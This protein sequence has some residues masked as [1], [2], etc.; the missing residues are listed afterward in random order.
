MWLLTDK[1]GKHSSQE[2]DSAGDTG[3]AP[4][5][6]APV[7]HR[8]SS[9]KTSEPGS[10]VTAPFRKTKRRRADLHVYKDTKAYTLQQQHEMIHEI[11][12]SEVWFEYKNKGTL[13][14]I[15]LDPANLM[16][17]S[18]TFFWNEI[19]KNLSDSPCFKSRNQVVVPTTARPYFESVVENKKARM[20]KG[21]THEEA[22]MQT[23]DGSDDG[24]GDLE[25]LEDDQSKQTHPTKAAEEASQSLC[26][27]IEETLSV[28]CQKII[29][30]ENERTG[31]HRQASADRSSKIG[32]GFVPPG[33]TQ[34]PKR[35]F[36][37][38]APVWR[39]CYNNKGN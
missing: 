3:S 16:S 9:S 22:Y 34:Q 7:A 11:V 32:P 8:T 13:Y 15:A 25:Q 17:G 4:S 27:E 1:I 33:K 36:D 14:S 38:P 37:P 12:Y 6:P 18:L 5:T 24:D 20:L 23:G 31:L 21:E 10:N 39:L 30:R 2:L 19:C 28:H 29:D 35:K 26:Y